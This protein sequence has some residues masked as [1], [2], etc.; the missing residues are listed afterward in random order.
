[1]NT[2]AYNKIADLVRNAGRILLLTDERIDGDTTGS[3]L[4]LFHVLTAMGKRVD[5]FSPKPIPPTYNF[6][7]GVEHISNDATLFT[8]PDI[9]LVIISDCSDGAYLG[10]FLATMP[11]HVPLAVFDHHATNPRYGTVNCIEPEAASTADVVWRF[12]K[13]AGF[14]M[15]KAAAQC[16]LTGITTDTQAF[17]STNTTAAAVEA[18]AEL[19]KLGG[20]LHDIVRHTFMNKSEASLKLWGLA[21]ERLFFD[22][23]FDAIATAMT[24][25]DIHAHG[26]TIEDIEGISNFLNA[27]LDESHE[28]VVV[29]R[30]TEDGAVKGSVRSRGRDVAKQAEALY[31]GGGHK[32]AAGFKIK[33]AHL[34]EHDGIWSVIKNETAV[35]HESPTPSP[36]FIAT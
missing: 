11:R 36:N 3:T 28:V 24:L 17:F 25:N 33:N 19:T 10:K 30:E 20:R 13:S 6:M 31:G 16:L 9:D 7:P 4:G 29:Y 8:Q 35:I 2:V 1:M 34:E 15:N 14:P 18:S 5:V 26:A 23:T 32:L 27:M 12:I 21:F 22:E